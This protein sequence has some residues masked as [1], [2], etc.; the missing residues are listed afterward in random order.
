M[1]ARRRTTAAALVG[2]LAL[3]LI[4]G[5]GSDSPAAPVPSTTAAETASPAA[6]VAAEPAE[7]P[8]DS[9]IPT[10]AAPLAGDTVTAEQAE[11]LPQGQ[12]AYEM[13]D[14]S[15]VVIDDRAPLPEAVRS[16]MTAPIVELGQVAAA[17][18][19]PTQAGDQARSTTKT[20]IAEQIA[21]TASEGRNFY[22]IFSYQAD[23]GTFYSAVSGGGDFLF[24]GVPT[25][26]EAIQ[27]AQETADRKNAAGFGGYYEVIVP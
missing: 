7:V 15:L 4:A 22:V 23:A 6:P 8:T 9:A 20:A 3:A 18:F 12:R 21:A 5:C 11:A 19:E 24:E 17:G 26:D 10:D 14:G 1:T 13:G 2:G 27:L 16:E 25:K